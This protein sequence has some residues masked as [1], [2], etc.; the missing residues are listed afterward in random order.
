MLLSPSKRTLTIRVLIIWTF[1]ALSYQAY[2]ERASLWQPTVFFGCAASIAASAGLIRPGVTQRSVKAAA[3]VLACVCRV[4]YSISRYENGF[5]PLRSTLAAI[6]LY[7]L[8]A[9]LAVSWILE[10]PR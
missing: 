6:P 3:I 1:A 7:L 4:A 9:A 5:T 2:H 10:L 8:L